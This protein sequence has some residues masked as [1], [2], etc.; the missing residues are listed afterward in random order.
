[1]CQ[2]ALTHLGP[3]SDGGLGR[4][5][6]GMP[7]SQGWMVCWEA[8][9]LVAPV[10]KGKRSGGARLVGAGLAGAKGSGAK[11]PGSGFD[12]CA[13]V[14]ESE[15]P[16]GGGA[17]GVWVDELC[18]AGDLSDEVP[19]VFDGVR[20][21]WVRYPCAAVSGVPGGCGRGAAAGAACG[22]V[23]VGVLRGR[24]GASRGGWRWVPAG[25]V[26]AGRKK[27][28]QSLRLRLRSGL[29][30]SGGHAHA[31]SAAHEWGTRS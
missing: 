11:G 30:Q 19:G 3:G 23:W 31:P 12:D 24:R 13:W 4:V 16:G 6:G 28:I 21:E 14:C 25:M 5:V 2:G 9:R 18:G 17:D 8:M 27:A 22:F 10:G 20:R 7:G 26:V 29:R 15:S 1:M